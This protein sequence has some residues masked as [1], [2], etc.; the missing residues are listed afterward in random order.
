MFLLAIKEPVCSHLA[1]QHVDASH[2]MLC[3]MLSRVAY[4]R[5]VEDR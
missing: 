1:F 2:I 5:Q 3:E 4:A